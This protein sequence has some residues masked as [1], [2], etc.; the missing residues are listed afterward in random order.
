MRLRCA[1]GR[2]G[3]GATWCSLTL[4]SAPHALSWGLGWCSAAPFN[5][6]TG[7]GLVSLDSYTKYMPH[8]NIPH[9][10]PPHPTPS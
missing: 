9:P 8:S 10:T 5:P 1:P 3:V 2:A 7:G 4:T 6:W